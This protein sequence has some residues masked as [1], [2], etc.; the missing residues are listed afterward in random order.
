MTPRFSAMLDQHQLS[1]DEESEAGKA[2]RGEAGS[3][4]SPMPVVEPKHEKR[5]SGV[6]GLEENTEIKI[7]EEQKLSLLEPSDDKGVQEPAAAK[8]EKEN[9]DDDDETEGEGAGEDG[10]DTTEDEEGV[11]TNIDDAMDEQPVATSSPAPVA[12]STAG[13]A[14][15]TPPV[16]FSGQ[17]SRDHHTTPSPPCTPTRPASDSRPGV[18]YTHSAPAGTTRHLSEHT[19]SPL[20]SSM[21]ATGVS[22]F[23]RRE[24]R[25]EDISQLTMAAHDLDITVSPPTPGMP[26]FVRLKIPALDLLHG[27]DWV[28]KCEFVFLF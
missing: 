24:A 19:Q 27:S 5:D 13:Q 3:K 10:G 22:R 11:I 17:L 25:M 1:F 23:R 2:A 8:E 9:D 12:T 21:V 15:P 16:G 26:P 20:S 4:K 6:A 18:D 28:P 14:K 7:L